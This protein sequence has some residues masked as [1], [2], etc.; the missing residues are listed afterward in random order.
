MLYPILTHICVSRETIETGKGRKD[1]F[2]LAVAIKNKTAANPEGVNKI[3]AAVIN[4]MTYEENER[5]KLIE[6]ITE[7]LDKDLLDSYETDFLRDLVKFIDE[8]GYI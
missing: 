6:Y 4:I 3:V 7:E 2:R 1:I 5:A 8:Y